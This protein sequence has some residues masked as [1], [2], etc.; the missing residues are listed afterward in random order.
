MRPLLSVLLW[1]VWAG[2]TGAAVKPQT[3]VNTQYTRERV[4]LSVCS[5]AIAAPAPL[6]TRVSDDLIREFTT[7]PDH[8]FEWAFKG[9]GL[10]GDGKDIVVL[11]VN[12]YTYDTRTGV[13]E[14]NFDFDIP[15]VTS[16]RDMTVKALIR[17]KAESGNRSEVSLELQ[18]TN[19]IVRKAG[20]ILKVVP[21]GSGCMM[22]VQVHF[23]FSWVM[24]LF[25]T[26][27][28]YKA[29]ME[30]RIASFMENLKN[31]AEKRAASAPKS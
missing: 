8:L 6:A 1:L 14:G 12:R 21:H 3:A 25:V 4:Y 27:K 23:R 7:D 9:L 15:G 10:Q 28:N 17:S 2:S 29:I 30:W 24:D 5:V 31:E 26:Q 22:I 11:T 18:N 16:F 13:Y 20:G 19:L